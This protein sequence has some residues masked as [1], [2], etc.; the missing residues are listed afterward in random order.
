[1]A[2]KIV[3]DQ[4]NP[5]IDIGRFLHET[6]Y[7]REKKEI[8]VG[9]VKMDVLQQGDGYLM[10]GEIKKSSSFLESS[11]MQLAYYLL[12][13]KRHGIEG[14]GMLMFPK[15]RKRETIE[16][17][18]Q[19]IKDLEMIERDI[20]KICEHPIPPQPVRIAMCNRCAYA[21]FCWA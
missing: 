18:D 8:I 21:E 4:D 15:E 16:L 6:S 17:N 13:L 12:E 7:G 19:L 10:V 5:D 2:H 3:P 1:M 14:K 20:L 9:D 11:K